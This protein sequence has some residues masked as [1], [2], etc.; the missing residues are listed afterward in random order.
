M[1]VERREREALDEK[2]AGGGGRC[3]TSFVECPYGMCIERRVGRFVE[4]ER[5]LEER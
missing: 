3:R 5:L 1:C 2:E 4:G